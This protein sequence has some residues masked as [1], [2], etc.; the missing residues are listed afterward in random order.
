M[1]LTRDKSRG[2]STASIAMVCEVCRETTRHEAGCEFLL[3]MRSAGE[4]NSTAFWRGRV[5]RT[6]T[7]GSFS[8]ELET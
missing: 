3:R 4:E 8:S 5:E 7:A 2:G 6:L 1:A